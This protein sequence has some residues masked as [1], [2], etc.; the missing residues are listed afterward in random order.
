[1]HTKAAYYVVGILIIV[2]INQTWKLLKGAKTVCLF[3][4]AGHAPFLCPSPYPSAFVRIEA[5][6]GTPQLSCRG[7]RHKRYS[8]CGLVHHQRETCPE[9]RA[10]E[11]KLCKSVAC[12]THLY[13]FWRCHSVT[14]LTEPTAMV[15][16]VR[17][18]SGLVTTVTSLTLGYSAKIKWRLHLSHGLS[19]TCRRVAP[20][21]RPRTVSHLEVT[22]VTLHILTDSSTTTLRTCTH[23]IAQYVHHSL[24]FK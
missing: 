18:S 7:P 3:L 2:Q 20:S 1:M 23:G 21:H 14:S 4:S 8:Q 19:V 13:R 10:S 15:T 9:H 22:G 11:V 5:S 16:I 17:L 6:H 12:A 24:S